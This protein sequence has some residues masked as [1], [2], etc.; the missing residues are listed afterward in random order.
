MKEYL[1]NIQIFFILVISI[2]VHDSMELAKEVAEVVGTGGWITILLGIGISIFFTYI[3]TYLGWSFRGKTLDQY[4][5]E[6]VGKSFTNIFVIIY[7]VY[8]FLIGAMLPQMGCEFLRLEILAKTPVWAMVITLFI[9]VYYT[10]SKGL[11][12]I[13]RLFEFYGF[14]IVISMFFMY[15]IM[16][17][18]GKM[19][20][21]QPLMGSEESIAYIKG[22]EKV[23]PYIGIQLLTI[24]PFEK[25]NSQIFKY[26]ISGI[27]MGG[28]L[29][30]LAF[31]ACIA[32]L[33]VDDIVYYKDALFVAVRRVNV[34]YLEFFERIDGI[35]ISIWFMAL[36]AKTCIYIYGAVYLLSKIFKKVEFKRLCFIVIILADILALIPTTFESK[37]KFFMYSGYM[38]IFTGVII[39]LILFITA[40]VK[41]YDKKVI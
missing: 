17:N 8:F 26:T 28:L 34:P 20:N 7:I 38:S 22:L 41:K 1:T 6:I 3:I 16:L 4:S 36:I 40:K 13:G 14:I 19:I 29:F 12:I 25:N 11:R 31:E 10:T 27:L 33:G 23:V 30:I 37:Q 32:I 18:E 5:N 35:F 9:V 24:I 21:L 15:I 2:T 39:P